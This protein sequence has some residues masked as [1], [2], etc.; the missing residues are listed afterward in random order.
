M[1][2]VFSYK[3]MNVGLINYKCVCEYFWYSSLVGC[4]IKGSIYM[5]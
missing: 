1:R 2:V 4:V 5:G 3:C